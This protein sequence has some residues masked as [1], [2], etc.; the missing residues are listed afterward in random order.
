MRP[1]QIGLDKDLNVIR[2]P[3]PKIKR[4]RFWRMTADKI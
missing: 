2:R 3:F 1:Y 4:R